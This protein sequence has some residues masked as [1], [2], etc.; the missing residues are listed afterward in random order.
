MSTVL[1]EPSKPEWIWDGPCQRK[2]A[3]GRGAK[4]IYQA[5]RRGDEVIKVRP[6]PFSVAAPMFYC[7]TQA[8][9][10]LTKPDAGV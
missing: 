9:D 6:R 5:I 8:L 4:D 10:H 2:N 3:R 7:Y 1:G